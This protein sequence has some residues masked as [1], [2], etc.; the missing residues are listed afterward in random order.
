MA[1][2]PYSDTVKSRQE[3]V[4]SSYIEKDVCPVEEG[5]LV[6]T[7]GGDINEKD[8]LISFPSWQKIATY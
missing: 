2:V 6:A 5:T 8:T 1:Q 3:L 7:L 4:A